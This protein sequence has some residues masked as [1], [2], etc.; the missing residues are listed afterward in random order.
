MFLFIASSTLMLVALT[1]TLL[2]VFNCPEV[3]PSDYLRLT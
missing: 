2:G 1:E 3:L